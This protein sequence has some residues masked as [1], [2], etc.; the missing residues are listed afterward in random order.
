M[1]ENVLNVSRQQ[2]Y[3]L[4]INSNPRSHISQ[5]NIQNWPMQFTMSF[6]NTKSDMIMLNV[7][8][9]WNIRQ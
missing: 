8:Q 4:C 9:I 2:F 1:Y 3:S 7:L 6:F 5:R